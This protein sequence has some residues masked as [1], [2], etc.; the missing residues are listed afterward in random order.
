[1]TTRLLSMLLLCA[2]PAFAGPRWAN[3]ADKADDSGHTF[4]CQGEGKSD[5]DA[6]AAA[7]GI[8]EDKICK[9]CGVEVE[10]VVET[11][12]TLTGVDLQRKVVERCRRVKRGAT[13]PKYKS[14]ECGPDGCQAWV[15]VLYSKA[16]EKA[17][18]SKFQSEDFADP[19]ACEKD[20]DTFR[21]LQGRDA[22]SFRKRASLL[23]AALAHCDKIDVRPTPA[24]MALDEKLRAGMDEF[25]F[26]QKRQNALADETSWMTRDRDTTFGD[27]SRQEAI[28]EFRPLW[29]WY[30]TTYEPLRQ[31][32]AES[33]L[34][35][36]RIKLVRDLVA[37][38]ALVFDVLEAALSKE[39][40]SAAGVQRLLKA[41]QAAPTGGQYGS[42]DV[43]WAVLDSLEKLKA[44]TQAIQ[45][46]YRTA[47]P[48]TK[49]DRFA[50]PQNLVRVF[51]SDG[52]VSQEE[53][54]WTYA[55]IG[56]GQCSWCSRMLLAVKDHGAPETRLTRAQD[57]LEQA[58]KLSRRAQTPKD[59]AYTW[60]N[61]GPM[62]DP[63]FLLAFEPRL[64]PEVRAWLDWGFWKTVL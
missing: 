17:E 19:A 4:T 18:C 57:A 14:S 64:K 63:A 28:D 45:A 38:K 33:K 52:A 36:Q 37:N 12:E 39:L 5:E 6:L 15:Q 41:V 60:S 61:L 59:Q 22:D 31:D 46:W 50:V 51:A 29:A 56:A 2:L 34:L 32:F 53:W 40:D 49:L 55:M 9:V 10:S 30:L 35:T 3:D 1:M 62:K 8:C 16:D 44:D 48:P 24:L 25:E 47:Y 42:P 21:H 13:V 23:T 11:K 7:L 27:H 58:I 43:H 54:D 26:T 20:I